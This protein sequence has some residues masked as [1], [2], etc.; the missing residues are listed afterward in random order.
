MVFLERSEI[1]ESRLCLLLQWRSTSV[2]EKL[3]LS[4]ADLSNRPRL[5]PEMVIWRAVWLARDQGRGDGHFQRSEVSGTVFAD[6]K[7]PLK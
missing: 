4:L 5:R 1:A 7:F 2:A 3:R 6:V